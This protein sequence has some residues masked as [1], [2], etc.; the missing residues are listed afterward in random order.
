MGKGPTKTEPAAA[1]DAEA[2]QE[3]AELEQ[4]LFPGAPTVA[5]LNEA[6]ILASLSA[7]AR[8]FG[9]DRET[10]RRVLLEREVQPVAE[11]AGHKLYAA[12]HVYKAWSEGS[13]ETDPDKLSPFK[14]RAWYQGERE[15]MHLQIER[16]E[17]VAA[18]EVERTMG[19]LLQ[20]AVRG[21]ETVQD[22]IERDAGLTPQQAAV[23]ERHIDRIREELYEEI[24]SRGSDEDDGEEGP[25][26]RSQSD[27]AGAT[28]AQPPA[29]TPPPTMV[30]SG[31]SSA[32][33][34]AVAFLRRSLAAGA[35]PTAELIDDAKKVGLSEAT[36]RRAKAQMGA[37]VIARRQGRGWVWELAQDARDA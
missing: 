23:L 29:A 14:R 31:G 21:F 12:R 18:I 20:I 8:A 3:T 30:P 11:R 7:W 33:D 2:G 26:A 28:P 34:D 17:L 35:R 19:R 13:D 9:T 36:L 32:V 16:G 27:V 15:K 5:N 37:A 25:A 10:L 6:D 1:A 4:S 24:V 22:R